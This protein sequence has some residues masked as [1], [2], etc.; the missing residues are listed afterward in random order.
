MTALR[1]FIE[2]QVISERVLMNWNALPKMKLRT[3]RVDDIAEF[4]KARD[5]EETALEDAPTEVRLTNGHG[6]LVNQSYPYLR[7]L[8]QEAL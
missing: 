4:E 7:D 6:L 2:V 8:I 5:Y 3:I 1:G